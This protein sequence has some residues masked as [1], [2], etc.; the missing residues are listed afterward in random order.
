MWPDICMVPKPRTIVKSL[1]SAPRYLACLCCACLLLTCKLHASASTFSWHVVLCDVCSWCWVDCSSFSLLSAPSGPFIS[2]F[3]SFLP[4]ELVP[5]FREKCATAL[6]IFCPPLYFPFS[7]QSPS[8][9][10]Q[11]EYPEQ[12]AVNQAFT[13]THHG[14]DRKGRPV[15]YELPGRYDSGQVRAGQS[16]G[17]QC[18]A[19]CG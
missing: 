13:G 4:A 8:S 12:E 11:Y 6:L 17:V 5:L 15:T 1:N 16:S 10:S 14:V 2:S 7:I 19:P 3:G 9:S 18:Y